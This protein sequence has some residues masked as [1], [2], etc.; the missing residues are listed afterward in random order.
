MPLFHHRLRVPPDVDP[1]QPWV[2]Q[3]I[4]DPHEVPVVRVIAGTKKSKLRQSRKSKPVY[5]WPRIRDILKFIQ[6]PL[7]EMHVKI[8]Q[9]S[10]L[11]E[12]VVEV[13]QFLQISRVVRFASEKIPRRRK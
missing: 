10:L 11:L 12:L 3:Q 4:P 13:N 9:L 7:Q 2:K 6:L 8:R 1:Y 5:F